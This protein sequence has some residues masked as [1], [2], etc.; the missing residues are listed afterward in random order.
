M[1]PYVRNVTPNTTQK[2]PPSQHLMYASLACTNS[3]CS[4]KT[5]DTHEKAKGAVM[6]DELYC[7][8]KRINAKDIVARKR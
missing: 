6:V 4:F 8:A 5:I 1:V 2:T 7:C 3:Y